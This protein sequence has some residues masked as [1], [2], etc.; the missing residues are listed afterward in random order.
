MRL[1]L[2]LAILAGLTSLVLLGCAVLPYT[3]SQTE[4]NA[5][6]SDLDQQLT[7]VETDVR[8]AASMLG[9][10]DWSTF[11]ADQQ[12]H[13]G[14]RV[15]LRNDDF[16]QG[17]L[18]VRESCL[19]LLTEDVEFGPNADHDFTINRPAQNDK[20]PVLSGF[21][22][23]FFAA[24]VIVGNRIVLDGQNHVLK[25]HHMHAALQRFYSHIELASSV[26]IVG[27]GPVPFGPVFEAGV[28]IVISNVRFGRTSHFSVSGNGN[29]NVKLHNLHMSD[30][31]LATIKL[32]GVHN[33]WIRNATGTG[34][35]TGT[36]VNAEFSQATFLLQFMQTFSGRDEAH[37]A[38][39]LKLR[40]LH[41]QAK[42]DILRHD[43]IDASKHAEAHR[44]FAAQSG[45]QT[46]GTVATMMITDLGNAVGPFQL[47]HT[48]D[49]ASKRVLIEDVDLDDTR[50]HPVEFVSLVDQDN[51]F[52]TGPAG[53]LFDLQRVSRDYGS[54][55]ADPLSDAI[56]HFAKL[57]ASGLTDEERRVAGRPNVPQPLVDWWLETGGPVGPELWQLV[58]QHGWAIGANTDGMGHVNKGAMVLRVQSSESVYLNNVN[59]G[60]VHA[61]GP[62]A[63]AGR[64][65]WMG[66]DVDPETYTGR[67]GDGGHPDQ[68]PMVG[69]TG[70]DARLFAVS[71][72]YNVKW[73]N[74]RGGSVESLHGRAVGLEQFED[75]Q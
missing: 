60:S 22:L 4:F 51:K 65:E 18:V 20:Y 9:T 40:Q 41:E 58:E 6:R 37:D 54:F 12:K 10:V 24:I 62:P 15:L 48:Q 70:N 32:N 26:F 68:W 13:A 7:G 72:S 44:L 38:A 33:A 55:S 59:L 31:E 14:K 50:C 43:A 61:S 39:Y 21:Q 35:F 47:G 64:R 53:E 19:L 30:Y 27:E 42:H 63:F 75:A 71:S 73:K 2:L 25:Q 69:Y 17:T 34:L 45:M 52:I 67:N 1:V 16:K 11:D 66:V 56:L 29:R 28:D 3:E 5:M 23:G 46:G 74:L 8:R 49:T 36:P 57:F